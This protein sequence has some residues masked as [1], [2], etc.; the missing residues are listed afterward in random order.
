MIQSGRA[1][2]LVLSFAALVLVVPQLAEAQDAPREHD[3]G[4]LIRLSFG[5]GSAS[6]SRDLDP[7][8][9]AGE[10]FEM[11]EVGGN[12]NLAIGGIVGGKVA[13]H[14]T[15]FG[16]TV[17][18]P[19]YDLDGRSQQQISGVASLNALGGGATW[20]FTR[21][22]FYLSGSVGIAWLSF[23]EDRRVLDTSTGGAV[24]LTLGKEW[25]A[26]DRWGLGVAIGLQGYNIPSAGEDDFQGGSASLR[27]SA[28]FN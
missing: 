21:H 17:R 14:A 26:S 23:R 22:N 16:W 19:N 13:L 10:K 3:G 7:A 24:D 4:I 20:Y 11:D 2:V 9:D 27:F 1:R 15:L 5:V 18:N 8:E 28:T 6:A 12:H 25:W